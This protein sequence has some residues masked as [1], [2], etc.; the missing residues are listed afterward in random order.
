[1]IL[2]LV[3]KF[4]FKSNKKI[5]QPN[6]KIN[7]NIKNTQDILNFINK[8]DKNEKESLVNN[9]VPIQEKVD[10]AT[11]EPDTKEHDTKEH[12]TKYHVN[13][14]EKP[15]NNEKLIDKKIK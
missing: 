3:Y 5:S 2:I 11:K 15:I 9:E 6:Q 4:L 13:K 14:S 12:D 7:S 10:K 8:E 1:M